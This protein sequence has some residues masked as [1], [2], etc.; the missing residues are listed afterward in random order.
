MR[1]QLSRPGVAAAVAGLAILL[2]AA[3]ARFLLAADEAQVY[4]LGHPLHWVCGFYARFGLPCPTCGLT[5]SVILSL[6]GEIARAWRVAPGGPAFTL[7]VLVAAVG[8]L[9]LAAAE[10]WSTQKRAENW[11]LEPGIKRALA[12]GT[13]A[14]ACVSIAI[15]LAGW[16]GQFSTALRAVH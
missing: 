3:M 7:G 14:W 4:V 13:I 1:N 8:L 5:R 15:W 2:D 16:A 11:R 10:L 6:H 12:T 9:M